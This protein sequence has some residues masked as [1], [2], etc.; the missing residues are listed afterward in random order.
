M[1][2]VKA[3]E[4]TEKIV[5]VEAIPQEVVPKRKGR[6]KGSKDKNPGS[7]PSTVGKKGTFEKGALQPNVNPGDNARYLRFA[8]E[9]YHLPPI[10]ISDPQQVAE[11]IDYY[12]QKCFED[13]MKPGVAGL[14]NYLGID[15]MTWYSWTTGA[16]R[17]STH[18]DIA[19]KTQAILENMWESYFTN[20]KL[21]PVSGIFIAKNHFGYQDRTEVVQVQ[22]DPLA[23]GASPAEIA[24]RYAQ[25]V[26]AEDPEPLPIGAESSAETAEEAENLSAERAEEP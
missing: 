15:R 10:D 23:E 19:K 16:I 18:H 22:K 9:G 13:D 17:A 11:R 14:C 20:G 21:N 26:V 4:Q 12:F 6:P 8:L 24:S 2:S 7:R 3:A 5:S 1:E 25:A